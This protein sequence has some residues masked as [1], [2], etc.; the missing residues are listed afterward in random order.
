MGGNATLTAGAVGLGAFTGPFTYQWT[1]NGVNLPGAT[2]TNLAL[3]NL[4]VTNSGNY[5]CVVST[6]V[7]SLTSAD[8]RLTVYSPFNL[9]GATFQL[10]GLVQIVA[11]GDNG[12]SYRLEASTNL[13]NWEPVVTN[14]ILGGS[15]TF[16][17][18]GAGTNTR[19]FY[20][21]VLLP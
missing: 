10:G 15:A 4:Q 14:T 3:T 13:V 21:I 19:R 20:R 16:T 5:A 6:S 1:F 18:S 8:A 7:G 9:G 11:S 2:T 12:R 17:D